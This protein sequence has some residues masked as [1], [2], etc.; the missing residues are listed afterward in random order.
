MSNVSSTV[1]F[2]PEAKVQRR[3]QV[4]ECSTAM[5]HPLSQVTTTTPPPLGVCECVCACA[6]VFMR[7]CQSL[8][9]ITRIV[10]LV[11]AVT[12]IVI[13]AVF[14]S[15]AN[16]SVMSSRAAAGTD[17]LFRN[18]HQRVFNMTQWCVKKIKKPNTNVIAVFDVLFL[19][20]AM[21]VHLW[22]KR[23]RRAKHFQKRQN[24]GYAV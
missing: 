21:K 19:L 23:W 3:Q 9:L 13:A 17:R 7:V 12:V 4:A 16:R 1:M 5:E 14:G 22:G 2:L 8:T 15:S 18:G 10:P 11:S 6:C 24:N 20:F